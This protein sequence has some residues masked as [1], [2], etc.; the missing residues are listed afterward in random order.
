MHSKNLTMFLMDGTPTGL[1]KCTIGNWIG[2]VYK[3]P[4]S[5]LERC[6]K[7]KNREDLKQSGV[8]FLFGASNATGKP[9]AYIGQAGNRKNG[10]GILNRLL[11]HK[12]TADKDYWTYAVVVTTANNSF[13]PTEISFLENKFCK[14][15]IDT[16]RYEVKNGNDPSP[17][18]IT[19]EKESEMDHFIENTR[20]IMWALNINIFEPVSKTTVNLPN[21]EEKLFY[22]TRKIKAIN[23]T[24]Q[25]I[26]KKTDEGFFVL[27]GSKIS[28]HEIATISSSMKKIRRNANI[29][30]NNILLE[31]IKF[32]SPSGAAEFVV[33]NNV[34]GWEYWKT[35]DGVELKD[36]ER[37]NE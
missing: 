35:K 14:L 28:P 32:S 30:S 21:N 13:G 18:N 36:L 12:R 33:G 25:G 22:L 16:N 10:E 20:L 27:K 26:G 15:A 8:Y 9:V 31:D 4:K 7:D 19:E 24:V 17:G 6:K 2:I 5:E 29:D 3:I 11:E 37:K 23:F 34:N 1:I